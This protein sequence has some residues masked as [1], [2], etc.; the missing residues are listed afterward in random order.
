[1]VE[2]HIDEQQGSGYLILQSNRSL[3]WS[4]NKVFLLLIALVSTAISGGFALIGAWLIFPFAGIEVL[5]LAGCVVYTVKQR[6]YKEIIFLNEECLVWQLGADCPTSERS[7]PRYW[8]TFKIEQP[9]SRLEKKRLLICS[10]GQ[11]QEVGLFLSDEEKL[12]VLKLL[13][14]NH[15]RWQMSQLDEPR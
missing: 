11:I 13:E 5:L 9:L 4:G 10:H 6:R 12:A 1:M 7:W 3:D 2:S 15:Q 14:I 8:V